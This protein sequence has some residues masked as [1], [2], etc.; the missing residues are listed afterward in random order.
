MPRGTSTARTL[1]R[2][3]RPEHRRVRRG[4]RC[5][6]LSARPVEHFL[7]RA[8]AEGPAVDLLSQVVGCGF[9]RVGGVLLDV[10]TYCLQ[11]LGGGDVGAKAQDLQVQCPVV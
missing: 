9:D 11:Y 10:S 2:P 5:G 6:R 8:D 4:A 7:S 1:P 3:E